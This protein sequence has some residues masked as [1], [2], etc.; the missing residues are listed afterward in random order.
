MGDWNTKELEV[1]RRAVSG[2]TRCPGEKPVVHW[3][4]FIS[5]RGMRFQ[6]LSNEQE[7]KVSCGFPRVTGAWVAVHG[8]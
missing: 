7:P 4:A 5:R 3:P 6:V 1:L 8:V 2:E